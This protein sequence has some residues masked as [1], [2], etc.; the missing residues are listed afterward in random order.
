MTTRGD[1]F[2]ALRALERQGFT[3]QDGSKHLRIVAPDGRM[4]HTGIARGIR[5]NTAQMLNMLARKGAK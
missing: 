4:A 5:P 1:K 3:V 2:K